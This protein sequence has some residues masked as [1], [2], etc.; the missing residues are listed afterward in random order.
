MDYAKLLEKRDDTRPLYVQLK[1][2]LTGAIG[3]GVLPTGMRLPSE[4]ELA[5]ELGLSRTT[6]VTAYRE[7]ESLGLV[8]SH[9]G[10]GT[11]VC[12]VPEPGDA[13]FAW[14][15]KVSWRVENLGGKLSLRHLMNGN[16][17]DQFI[18]FAAGEPAFECFPLEEYRRVITQTLKQHARLALGLAPTEGQPVLRRAVARRFGTMPER[19]LILSGSQQGIDL[20]ARCLIDHSDTIIID[21]PGYVGAIQTFRAAGANIVGWDVVRAD[22]DEL[23][24][25]IVRHRPK[26]IY[27]DPTFQNPTGRTM[28]LKERQDLLKLAARYRIPI[29]EDD[30]WRETYL[31]SPPPLSLCQLDVHNIVIHLGTFS[32]VL[33]PGLRLGWL[34]ASEYIVDQLASIKQH[35]NLFNEGLSQ[36]VIADF[37]QSGLFDTHLENLR[38]KHTVKRDLMKR[39]AAEHLPARMCVLNNPRG[40]LHFWCQLM[41]GMDAR[42]LL[43]AAVR[44]GVS[45]APGELFYPDEAGGRQELRLCF[46][47][48]PTDRIEEGIKR[49]RG[50]FDTCNSKP[51]K[52]NSHTPLV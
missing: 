37:L 22:L 11:F 18:S 15:G 7:L 35:E 25:L 45:F 12:A 46:S 39:A 6:V 3:S 13:P 51:S 43:D 31:D 1:E 36:I 8:R 26:L 49:L 47:S 9:V 27:T 41:K 50:A 20:I 38:R 19:V 48:V 2:A 10:R 4:R 14:R 29:I 30:P 21:R 33:A 28:T 32:K 23:E 5:R 52:D 44:K 17:D 34:A 42:H 24:D 16:Q 40:G